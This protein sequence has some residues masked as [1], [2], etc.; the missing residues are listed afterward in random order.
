MNTNFSIDEI[1]NCLD[2]KLIFLIM[3]INEFYLNQITEINWFS[4]KHK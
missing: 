3:L 2:S 1:V 4:I